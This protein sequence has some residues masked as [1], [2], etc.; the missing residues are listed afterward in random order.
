MTD[1]EVL[2][3]LSGTYFVVQSSVQDQFNHAYEVLVFSHEVSLALYA[4]DSAEAVFYFCQNATLRSLTVGT[5]SC[6]SLSAFAEQVLRNLKIAVCFFQSLLD[7]HHTCARNV[8]Q[9]LD[10]S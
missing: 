4:Y 9:F 5:F 3:L 8:A 1:L 7:V 2:Q 10:I 6:D